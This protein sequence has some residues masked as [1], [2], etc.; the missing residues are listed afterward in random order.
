MEKSIIPRAFLI[1][2]LIGI[3]YLCYL[4]FKPFLAEIIVAGVL[5]SISY[6]A[7]TW[8]AGF[9]K[10]RKKTAALI[11][12]VL[13]AL[14]AIV[15]I[16]NFI[17]YAA[18]KLVET[19]SNLS[20]FINQQ[21]LT[22]LAHSRFLTDLGINL[23]GN[24]QGYIFD[25][26]K[27]ANEWIIAGA[28]GLI[29]GTTNFIFSL[30]LIILTMF[31]FLI[32]GEGMLKKVMRW[33]P[34]PNKYDERIFRKFRAVSYST[35]VSTFVTAIAQGILG[36]LGFLIV[37]LPAFMG[38]ILIAFFSLVPYVGAGIIWGPAAV[39]LLATGNIWQ[40]IFL[41]AFGTGGISVI[42]N[43]IRAYIIKGKSEVHPIFIIFSILGGVMVF[44]FWGIVFGPL[45]ISLAVTILHIYELEYEEI[46]EK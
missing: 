43:L 19:Y 22:N 34:L 6:P 23:D 13:A 28:K 8:L 37:G 42:D 1:F 36:G 30:S 18:R 11:I 5:A 17:V 31:F 2:L 33:T 46:L 12:T 4:V 3:L 29:T 24:L 44:G 21:S 20:V 26:L 45:I 40:G 16:A 35:I 15:P 14:I 7:Y 10:G 38:G 39:Y 9:L 41:I 32:D 27:Q 25:A